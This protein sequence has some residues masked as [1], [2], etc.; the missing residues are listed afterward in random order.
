VWLDKG[1]F[2]RTAPNAPDGRDTVYGALALT[3]SF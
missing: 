2:L 1:R 3:A